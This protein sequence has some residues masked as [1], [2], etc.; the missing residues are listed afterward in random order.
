MLNSTQVEV[1]VEGWVDLGNTIFI[2][3]QYY[4]DKVEMNAESTESKLDWGGLSLAK[5]DVFIQQYL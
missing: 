1:V 5:S 2:L 4:I 3:Y